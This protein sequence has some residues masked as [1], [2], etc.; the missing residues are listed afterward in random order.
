MKNNSAAT[1]S[2][3]FE[4]TIVHLSER[5]LT[6]VLRTQTRLVL[7]S[8][9]DEDLTLPH[10]VA[11]HSYTLYMHVPFCESLCP[12]C[13]FNRFLYEGKKAVDYFTALREE[14]RM[15]ADMGYDF[16]T[17]Y[18]GG[19]TPTINIEEL[20]KTID[21]AR[22]LFNIHEVSCETN[23]NHLVPEYIEQ[24]KDRVQRLSVGVQSFDTDLLQQMNRLE[25]FGDGNLILERIRYAAPFFESLN[26]DMIFNFPNQTLEML[27]VDLDIILTSG[28]QQ[29]TFYPLMSASSVEKSMANSVGK[30]SHKREWQFFNLI[31]DRLSGEFKQLSAWTFVR[32]AAGMIDEYIVDSEEYVGIGSGSFSYLNGT[33]FVNHFS[34]NQYSTSVHSGKLGVSAHKK[35]D[36]LSQMRYW[37]MMNLFGMDFNRQAFKQRFGTPIWFGLAMEMLF[38]ELTGAFKP[39]KRNQLTRRGQY[40]SVV[41]MREFFAGVNNLRDLARKNLSPLE[42][43]SATPVKYVGV[44]NNSKSVLHK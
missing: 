27:K 11:G 38:M 20:V 19:G 31:N 14:M 5:A 6:A 37:F 28:A 43:A 32:K 35:Y 13:S 24:L 4:N 10:P 7:T 16:K 29:V 30:P 3:W 15:V 33:L 34:I 18:I 9:A 44:H 40:M 36:R 26:V 23:P 2:N 25:K 12:Y 42:L 39:G 17:L 8:N 41:M 22:E 1:N 21:L